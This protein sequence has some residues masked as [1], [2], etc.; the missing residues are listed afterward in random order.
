MEFKALYLPESWFKCFKKHGSSIYPVTRPRWKEI[1]WKKWIL[2]ES[3]T[4]PVD[5]EDKED[6]EALTCQ[7][8][9]LSSKTPAKELAET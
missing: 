7:C 2:K 9:C 8:S 5:K 1:M 6:K 4:F 3:A